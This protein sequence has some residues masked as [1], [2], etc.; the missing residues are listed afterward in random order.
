M[1]AVQVVNREQRLEYTTMSEEQYNVYDRAG[2]SGYEGKGKG[3][4]KGYDMKGGKGEGKGVKGGY[5]GGKGFEGGKGGYE[6][7][8]G[9]GEQKGGKG[10]YE[11]GKGDYKGGKGGYEGGKGEYKGGKG[12]YEGYEGGKGDYKGGK[13]GYEG[14]EG[15]KGEYKGGKGGYEGGKG[16]Y[17]GGKP[18]KELAD[19]MMD[20][21][22]AL[23]ALQGR[24]VARPARLAFGKVG[25]ALTITVNHFRLECSAKVAFHFD[26]HISRGADAVPRIGPAEDPDLDLAPILAEE[27]LRRLMAAVALQAQWGDAWAYDGRKNVVSAVDLLGGGPSLTFASSVDSGRGRPENFQVV[28]SRANCIDLSLLQQF[29]DPLRSSDMP[30]PQLALQ[31]IDIVLKHH[32]GMKEGWYIKG[33]SNNQVFPPQD[34]RKALG[35]AMELWTGYSQTIRASQC[36]LTVNQDMA[37]AAFIKD[38][39][40]L[41]L[42]LQELNVRSPEVL[43]RNFNPNLLRAATRTLAGLQM[44]QTNIKYPRSFKCKAVDRVPATEAMFICKRK[45]DEVGEEMSVAQYFGSMYGGLQFPRLPCIDLG[46][47]HKQRLVPMEFCMVVKGQR[48]GKLDAAQTAELIRDAARAPSQRKDTI[49]ANLRKANLVSDPTC[50]EFGLQVSSEVPGS[51]PVQDLRSLSSIIPIR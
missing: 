46:T 33:K 1:N 43:E 45:G 10:G 47:K 4:G 20:K 31:A 42:L 5:E 39:E 7:G 18:A 14:Y 3:G 16:D 11:G 51:Q 41:P 2:G 23:Q 36:G 27:V 50:L 35:D 29:C 9:K 30:I 26:V 24:D 28:V 32:V 8:K 48:K 40:V 19:M 13:G 17:K 34:Y 15:G 22:S 49:M 12:A 44:Q 25:G 6:G 37:S 21:A 38:G